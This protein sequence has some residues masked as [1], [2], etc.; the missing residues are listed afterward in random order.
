M[1][2]CN[3]DYLRVQ[4]L[5]LKYDQVILKGE[6]KGEQLPIRAPYCQ[7]PTIGNRRCDKIKE[8]N[9]IP[10]ETTHNKKVIGNN[11]NMYA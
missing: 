3:P 1:L 8:K 6:P 7:I 11:K 2:G 4:F 10:T 5:T 9:S